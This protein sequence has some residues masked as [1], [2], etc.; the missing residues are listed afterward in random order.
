MLMNSISK[1][2]Q[3]KSEQKK[4]IKLMSTPHV[5]WLNVLCKTDKMI[6]KH[7]FVCAN[8]HNFMGLAGVSSGEIIAIKILLMNGHIQIKYL[9]LFVNIMS[10]EFRVFRSNSNYEALFKTAQFTK[11]LYK[12]MHTFIFNFPSTLPTHISRHWY[13]QKEPCFPRESGKNEQWG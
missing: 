11:V 13:I 7:F 10:W 6:L 2:K 8:L 12:H 3:Q 1:C 5:E 9:P 4:K